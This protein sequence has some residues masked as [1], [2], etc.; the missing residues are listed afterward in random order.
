MTHHHPLAFPEIWLITPYWP[1]LT[2]PWEVSWD[3]VLS[4]LGLSS[5]H[6]A[7]QLSCQKA[8]SMCS[9]E[10][11]VALGEYLFQEEF[12]A[13][14]AFHWTGT[15]EEF[16]HNQ[17]LVSVGRWQIRVRM[18]GQLQGLPLREG[19]VNLVRKASESQ[20]YCPCCCWRDG[21]MCFKDSQLSAQPG[22]CLTADRQSFQCT[23][24]SSG[25]MSLLVS[26]A[27]CCPNEWPT[28]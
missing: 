12:K 2:R 14:W 6:A 8:V 19:K 11:G 27:A 13:H 4:Q 7:G 22:C 28:L 26:P 21:G 10:P 18:R 17:S 5:R 15:K 23:V 16:A 20:S 3:S 25:L 1:A 9:A 24:I